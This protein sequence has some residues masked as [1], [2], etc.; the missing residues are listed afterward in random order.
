VR[1]IRPFG[2]Q[3]ASKKTPVGA[4]QPA[5]TGVS[6]LIQ[7]QLDV[8]TSGSRAI[9]KLASRLLAL[10]A[11]RVGVVITATWNEFEGIDWSRP[12]EPA[13]HAIWRV[14]AS[15][16]KL[17]VGNKANAALG[18]DVPL[19]A[20]AVEVLR[21]IHI[22]TGRRPWLFPNDKAWREPMSDAAV[23]TMYKRMDGGAYKGRMVPHGWRAAFS[24]VMNEWAA[25]RERDGDRMIIDMI[26]AHIP[27]GMSASEWA[28]NRAR[29]LKRRG[30]LLNVWAEMISKGLS[31]PFSLVDAFGRE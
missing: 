6:A 30:E 24:T 22:M 5:L 27:A 13:L 18:H 26:L 11:V 1:S 15:R 21:A 28:Y 7:L 10:T 23:S 29:Y 9:T 8:D 25:E 3:R 4:R 2:W 20:Q 16:M 14:P 12:D 19:S 17:S 31:S